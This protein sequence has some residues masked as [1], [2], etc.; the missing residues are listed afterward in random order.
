MY[1]RILVNKNGTSFFRTSRLNSA[2]EVRAALAII[3]SRVS[4]PNHEAQVLEVSDE[5]CGRI[6]DADEV[7]ALTNKALDGAALLKTSSAE[8]NAIGQSAAQQANQSNNLG[9]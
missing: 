7:A 6:L 4:P 5:H 9:S 1:Y 3:E 2:L 8:A